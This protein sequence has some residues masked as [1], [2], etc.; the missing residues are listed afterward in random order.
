MPVCFVMVNFDNPPQIFFA[1]LD[2]FLRK[3]NGLEKTALVL[4][5]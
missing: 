2:E 4:C 1:S 3:T 5:K